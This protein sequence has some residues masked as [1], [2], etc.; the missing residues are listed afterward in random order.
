MTKKEF[1]MRFVVSLLF[2]LMLIAAPA[3]AEQQ[4]VDKERLALG[5]EVLEVSGAAASFEKVLDI[6]GGQIFKMLVAQKPDKADKIREFFI[7][8]MKEMAARKGELMEQ[9]GRIYAEE[10]TAAELKE[11][12]AFYKTPVGQKLARRIPIIM[13]KMNAAGSTWGRQV[14]RDIIKKAKEEAKRRGID[15]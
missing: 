11:L 13:R 4:A 2:G 8:M 1:I 7:P 14:A 10:F 12:V 15:L 9:A 3:M 6:M 5:K